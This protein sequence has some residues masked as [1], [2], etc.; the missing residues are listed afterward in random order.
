MY[1]VYKVTFIVRADLPERY[2]YR[3]AVPA[4]KYLPERRSA[5]SQHHN[6]RGGVCEGNPNGK[7][8]RGIFFTTFYTIL[9]ILVQS[10][11][12]YTEQQYQNY[13][14]IQSSLIKSCFL[15]GFVITGCAVAQ[16]LC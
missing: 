11:S 16:A 12:S 9:R 5:A 3:S 10:A 7:R 6:P 1:F 8:I 13:T 2:I 15:P 4:Q 14:K